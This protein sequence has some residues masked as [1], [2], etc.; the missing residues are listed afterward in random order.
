MLPNWVLVQRAYLKQ[1][2][3]QLLKPGQEFGRCCYL[4]RPK[5]LC[6]WMSVCRSSW[7]SVSVQHHFL[8]EPCLPW[9]QWSKG[10]FCVPAKQ[11]YK[12]TV[13]IFL[14]FHSAHVK[15]LYTSDAWH[16]RIQHQRQTFFW[17]KAA[18]CLLAFLFFKKEYDSEEQTYNSTFECSG[19]ILYILF[20]RWQLSSLTNLY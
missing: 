4:Q 17:I 8:G 20:V 6:L 7:R 9:A 2:W 19:K 13:K 16:C 15:A 18:G 12:L 1:W 11:D 3:S 10:T 14:A 5:R